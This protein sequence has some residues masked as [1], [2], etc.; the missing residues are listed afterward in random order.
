LVP[1]TFS[2]PESLL[3][4]ERDQEM[5]PEYVFHYNQGL[6]IRWYA[7]E[8]VKVH[9]SK[10]SAAKAAKEGKSV[11]QEWVT[12]DKTQTKFFEWQETDTSGGACYGL[13]ISWIIKKAK[14]ED[15]LAWLKP[16]TRSCPEVATK[17]NPGVNPGAGQ[18]VADV[19][20]IQL[21]EK[22]KSSRKKLFTAVVHIMQMIGIEP[23]PDDLVQ[24][25]EAKMG[26]M[27]IE[28][29]EG[30][31]L[32]VIK[33]YKWNRKAKVQGYASRD[34]FNHMIAAQVIAKRN[35]LLF[36]PNRGE[37]KFSGVKDANAFIEYLCI[38][39]KQYHLDPTAPDNDLIW[40]TL[41][42]R[43]KRRRSIDCGRGPVW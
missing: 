32:I 33:G 25:R 16:G 21:L 27:V 22:N 10:E 3:K 14:G 2:E 34:K 18:M 12:E 36:D 31:T 28:E 9:D 42:G 6:D 30:F 11:T 5:E 40:T 41:A 39:K 4:I 26:D 17:K 8:I 24:V 37:I 13:V 19:K 20:K 1:G 23:P 29:K 35:V 7:S 43:L 38:D 15:F